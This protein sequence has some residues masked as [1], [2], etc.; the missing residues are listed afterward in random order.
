MAGTE[1]GTM[2]SPRDGTSYSADDELLGGNMPIP[3]YAPREPT[4]PDSSATT[5]PG[6]S[7]NPPLGNPRDAASKSDAAEFFPDDF[8]E[9]VISGDAPSSEA[10]AP[11]LLSFMEVVRKYHGVQQYLQHVLGDAAA[12][13]GFV[14]Y[15]DAMLPQLNDIHYVITGP[16]PFV[17]AGEEHLRAPLPVQLK[18]FAYHHSASLAAEPEIAGSKQLTDRFLTEGFITSSEPIT[19]RTHIDTPGPL[20]PFTMHCVKGITRILTVMAYFC[21]CS[22]NDVTPPDILIKTCSVIYVRNMNFKDSADEICYA[23]KSTSRAGI[24]RAF[25]IISWVQTLK[26]LQKKD[27]TLTATEL[28]KRWNQTAVREE[29]MVGNKQQV[30]KIMLE[31]PDSAFEPIQ[32]CVSELGWENS[33]CSYEN[34][35]SKKLSVGATFKQ[36]RCPPS[37][38]WFAWGSVA[39][40]ALILMADCL[41]AKKKVVAGRSTKPNKQTVEQLLECCCLAWHLYQLCIRNHSQLTSRLTAEFLDLLGAGDITIEIELQAAIAEKDPNYTVRDNPTLAAI[42]NQ[43]GSIV[44]DATERVLDAA[45]TG[46][47]ETAFDLLK[48]EIGYEQQCVR[49]WYSKMKAHFQGLHHQNHVWKNDVFK[50]TGDFVTKY[51]S[52]KTVIYTFPETQTGTFALTKYKELVA[53]LQQQLKVAPEDL[54]TIALVNWSAPSLMSKHVQTA[55]LQLINAILAENP[56]N[57]GLALFPVHAY[58]GGKLYEQVY[59]LS[60]ACATTGNMNVDREFNLVLSGRTD[61]R[62]ARPM[63]YPGRVFTLEGRAVANCWKK[64]PLILDGRTESTEMLRPSEMDVVDYLDDN[65]LPRHCSD[66]FPK[67]AKKFAQ[68]GQNGWHAILSALFEKNTLPS[69]AVI[70]LVDASVMWG[71]CMK[72]FLKIQPRLC[73]FYMG[74]HINE[75]FGEWTSLSCEDYLAKNLQDKTM[76]IPGYTWQSLTPPAEILAMEPEKPQLRRLSWN[77]AEDVHYEQIVPVICDDDLKRWSHHQ[78]FGAEF[79]ELSDKHKNEFKVVA[80]DAQ[81]KRP[82]TAIGV[83]GPS[84]KKAKLD[85]K[86]LV[87]ASSLSKYGVETCAVKLAACKMPVGVTAPTLSFCADGIMAVVNTADVAIKICYGDLLVGF[88]K[89]SFRTLNEGQ[90][91]YDSA[92]DIKFELKTGNDLAFLDQSFGCMSDHLC[93]WATDRNKSLESCRIAYHTIERDVGGPWSFKATLFQPVCGRVAALE[94]EVNQ[95]CAGPLKLPHEW[96]TDHTSVVWVLKP[97]VNGFQIVRPVVVFTSEID[98]PPNKAFVLG[99]A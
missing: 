49:V 41:W 48:K 7:L 96:S 75:E 83:P 6:L 20:Q 81:T 19:T 54:I 93:A 88:G 85:S 13:H 73:E 60:K 32:R 37:N 22:K 55:Q 2:E 87:D 43:H 26:K 86:L 58:K 35:S 89:V 72:A 51:L 84:P 27:S 92:K 98:I 36:Q 18:W 77:T 94:K 74:F 90:A 79:R 23:M 40:E 46:L 16:L 1:E 62:D 25:H 34:L 3:G 82:L 12:Q 99:S 70:V 44:G 50:S 28:I 57:L 64:T 45:A 63:M 47:D 4:T 91:E 21:W 66:V 78:R 14:T 53:R 15:L 80:A 29:K 52:R 9:S 31:L 33:W 67:E 56:A 30:L 59:A 71:Q 68:I 65:A 38:P 10:P 8:P 76:T 61:E 95:M 97:T 17:W 5:I 11:V 42:L 69:R 39:R 24:K